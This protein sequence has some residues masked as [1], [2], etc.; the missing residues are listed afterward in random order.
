[1]VELCWERWHISH[2]L[3]LQE[4]DEQPDWDTTAMQGSGW[5]AF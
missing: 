5:I 1:M 4:E 3:E 2:V